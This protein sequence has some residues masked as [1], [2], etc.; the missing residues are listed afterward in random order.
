MVR[1]WAPTGRG[2]GEGAGL[3]AWW[4]EPSGEARDLRRGSHARIWQS[5]AR[6][7]ALWGRRAFVMGAVTVVE[8]YARLPRLR[9]LFGALEALL[10]NAGQMRW[11]F[12]RLPARSAR[13]S[14]NARSGAAKATCS[15]ESVRP[16]RCLE[17]SLELA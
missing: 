14:H 7:E 17:V 5:L 2:G 3:R 4:A 1:G 6:C 9:G 8:V 15:P 13:P 10:G 12:A 16:C 11:L